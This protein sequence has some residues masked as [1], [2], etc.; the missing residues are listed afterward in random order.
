MVSRYLADATPATTSV[1]LRG[2]GGGPV[3][4]IQ[5]QLVGPEG[6]PEPNPTPDKPLRV[7]FEFA[8]RDFVQGFDIA[9]I[10]KDQRG[11]LL[12]DEAWSDTAGG[13]PPRE[14]APGQYE[15]TVTIPA[16]LAAGRYVV[17]AWFG[18]SYHD[19]FLTHDLMSFEILPNATIFR[20]G[21]TEI[22]RCN[23]RPAGA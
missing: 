13:T 1:D 19:D 2:A 20:S 6:L 21:S 3:E 4:L 16:L 23:Q 12:L 8:V 9:L 17:T 14:L 5:A 10:L 11:V 22:G 7:R 15:V 18:S